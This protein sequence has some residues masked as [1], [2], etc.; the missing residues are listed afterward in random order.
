MT[1]N[2]HVISPPALPPNAVCLHQQERVERAIEQM[3]AAISND[4]AQANPILLCVMNGG[5][6]LSSQL[7]LRLPFPL[8]FDYVHASRYHNTQSG[9][10]LE[11]LVKPQLSLQ[12]RV[13][14]VVD[15][16]FDEGL[17]LDA[18]VHYCRV[19]GVSSVRVAV[20]V[21]KLRPQRRGKVMP[22][23]V[24]LTV[25]DRYVF[26][27]GMDKE[28]YWRNLPGIYAIDE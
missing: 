14:L 28:N 16:I 25:P 3:A 20:L 15:D 4:L 22:N 12:D 27:Y 24:G 8:Q 11:W 10:E 26:G 17:T 1:K 21:E 2:N 19:A 13:V 7:M 9:G 23:Y 18:I 6:V 5:V